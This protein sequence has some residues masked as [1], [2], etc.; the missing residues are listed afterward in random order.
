MYSV[1]VSSKEITGGLCN[2]ITLQQ[3]ICCVKTEAN[4]ASE[5][6]KNVFVQL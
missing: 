3:F 4:E 1:L 5:I 2:M 6:T